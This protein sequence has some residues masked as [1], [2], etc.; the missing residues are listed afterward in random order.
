MDAKQANEMV[1]TALLKAEGAVLDAI[2]AYRDVLEAET[3]LSR[4]AETEV[5]REIAQRGVGYAT[6]T[7][8]VLRSLAGSWDGRP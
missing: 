6:M 7:L 3:Q 2:E 1:T 8:A 4:I 5:E